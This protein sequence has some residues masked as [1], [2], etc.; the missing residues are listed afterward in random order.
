[1]SYF[2]LV[3]HTIWSLAIGTFLWIILVTLLFQQGGW[4]MQS[5]KRMRLKKKKKTKKVPTCES[6]N[7][8]L[9]YDLWKVT[10]L[11]QTLVFSSLKWK[12]WS[13]CPRVS[14][15]WYCYSLCNMYI[16]LGRL[17]LW[18]LFALVAVMQKDERKLNA[19][20]PPS[21]SNTVPRAK[22]RPKIQ[23]TAGGRG[24]GQRQTMFWEQNAGA[25]L[26]GVGSKPPIA[27]PPCC[28]PLVHV[29]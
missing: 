10:R 7:C 1:M 27:P 18:E 26:W 15:E 13:I 4:K 29:W 25:Q 16:Y 20:F 12:E 2:E 24:P 3:Q 19:S 22:W 17:F 8:Q 9:L 6:E 5:S 14:K 28:N 23:I 21:L 11:H